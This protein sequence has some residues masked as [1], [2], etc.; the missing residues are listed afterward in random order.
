[1]LVYCRIIHVPVSH[2]DAIGSV[3]EQASL[4]ANKDVHTSHTLM[5]RSKLI[6]LVL[7]Q[8]LHNEQFH[9]TA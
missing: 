5:L 7:F 8:L 9:C 6:G 1:L 3:P 2:F 4:L